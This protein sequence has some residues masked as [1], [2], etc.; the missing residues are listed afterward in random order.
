TNECNE[1]KN[2]CGLNSVCTNTVGSYHCNCEV[3]FKSNMNDGKNCSDIDECEEETFNCTKF[4]QCKNLIGAYECRC[5]AGYRET[6]NG[7]CQDNNE[8]ELNKDICGSN[9]VCSN[10]GGS[11][12]C[13]CEVGYKSANDGGKKCFDIDECAKLEIC[14]DTATCGNTLGSYTCTCPDGF[15]FNSRKRICVDYDEC[16]IGRPCDMI[17]ANTFGSYTCSCHEGYRLDKMHCAGNNKRSSRL[18]CLCRIN[19]ELKGMEGDVSFLFCI[20]IDECQ[21]KTY[22]CPAFS[23]CKNQNGSYEC[24]CEDGYRK[25][26]DGTCSVLTVRKQHHHRY[27]SLLSSEI[28]HPECEVNSFCQNGKCMCKKGFSMGLNLTCQP[29]Q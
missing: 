19:R 8:C 11:Y 5:K 21:E 3:G 6:A 13:N 23:R 2:F 1:D 17:C 26:S 24:L 29:G 9:S 20:E 28:C 4:S 18:S 14:G 16:E 22:D 25:A 10:T 27:V 12:K 7:S 15:A